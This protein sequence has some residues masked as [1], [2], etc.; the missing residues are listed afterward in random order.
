M[1]HPGEGA[2]NHPN[3]FEGVTLFENYDIPSFVAEEG[4]AGQTDWARVEVYSEGTARYSF[5]GENEDSPYH[6]T[7]NLRNGFDFGSGL[8]D[9]VEARLARGRTM[10]EANGF[11][12]NQF[13][14]RLRKFTQCPES[15]I[16]S[17]I[18]WLLPVT[19]RA[20]SMYSSP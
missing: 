18:W 1:T 17:A 20:T 5:R 10:L 2:P 3:P 19:A 8:R 7:Q 12:L 9:E 16:F 6:I 15:R 14:N 11:D 4:V 13:P